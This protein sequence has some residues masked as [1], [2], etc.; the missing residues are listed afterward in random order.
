MAKG[1]WVTMRGDTDAVAGA[2]DICAQK[3]VSGAA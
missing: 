1:G 2:A 3:L